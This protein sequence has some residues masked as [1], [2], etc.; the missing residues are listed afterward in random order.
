MKFFLL[1]VIFISSTIFASQANDRLFE[2]T[3]IFKERK[4]ELLV[5]LERIDEQKQALSA[6]KSA[7]Q[8]LLKKKE[9]KLNIQQDEVNKK[10]SLITKKENSLKSMLAENKSVLK[11][12]KNLKMSKISQTFSKMKASAAAQIISDM[13]IQDA[14][15]ILQ[16]LK[17]K[18]VGQILSKM[19]PKKASDLAIILSK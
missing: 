9:T 11:K 6:L 13:K 8:E 14:S 12:L 2:C 7:T 3:Q 15:S 5:E 16:A 1:L 19:D 17:P 18:S 4:G 10:L